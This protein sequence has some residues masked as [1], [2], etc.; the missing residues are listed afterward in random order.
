MEEKVKNKKYVVGDVI[1]NIEI[2]A[3]LTDEKIHRGIAHLCKCFC[4]EEF[5]T[6]LPILLSQSNISCGCRDVELG[7]IY[8]KFTIVGKT[9]GKSKT[10][11]CKCEC[12]EVLEVQLA[13]L[14]RGNK[15]S[16]HNCVTHGKFEIGDMH[17]ELTIIKDLGAR[18][19][20][21]TYRYVLCKC[22]C[23][24]EK[25]AQLSKLKCGVINNCDNDIHR[26]T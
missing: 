22:S 9:E 26:K 10:Y 15:K 11:D 25:E 24:Q 8:W 14:E 18:G 3:I 7:D 19:D 12:G 4:G 2:L 21:R 13:R 17:G 1:N 20:D 6:N 5:K 23:G 16:C